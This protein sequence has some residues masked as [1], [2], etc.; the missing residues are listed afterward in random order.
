MKQLISNSRL[1]RQK[2][3]HFFPEEM[4]MTGCLGEWG[5]PWCPRFPSYSH[6]K[7]TGTEISIFCKEIHELAIS[8]GCAQPWQALP[9]DTMYRPSAGCSARLSLG[10]C[11]EDKQCGTLGWGLGLGVI[12]SHFSVRFWKNAGRDLF[13]HVTTISRRAIKRHTPL[14]G[15]I[16]KDCITFT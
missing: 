8:Y 2:I 10:P 1:Y 11:W 5:W 9:R 3:S 14:A 12:F 13:L 4:D 16:R 15:A 7:Q 6:E